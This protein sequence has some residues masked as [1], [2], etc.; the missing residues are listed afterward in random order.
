M[1]VTRKSYNRTRPPVP[2][3]NLSPKENNKK[4]QS[5]SKEPNHYKAP[6]NVEA[7]PSNA[8][9]GEQNKAITQS[10][11][12]T[13]KPTVSKTKPKPT[14]AQKRKGAHTPSNQKSH[15]FQ[16]NPLLKQFKPTYK[17]TSNIVIDLTPNPS[18][19]TIT[20]EAPPSS[21]SS[22]AIC[23]NKPSPGNVPPDISLLPT[24]TY[25]EFAR[26][27]TNK[28]QLP[29]D[30]NVARNTNRSASPSRGCMVDGRDQF[31]TKDQGAIPRMLGSTQGFSD[32][33]QEAVANSG[34]HE[35]LP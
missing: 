10:P 22:E 20:S 25:H 32:A 14:A 3:P 23:S 19:D 16:F 34:G 1:I 29:Q 30:Q 31:E 11:K 9:P 15:K 35:E 21:S 24:Q 28:N 12:P 8:G 27:S 6:V 7:G 18:P 17:P 33:G 26:S 2:T 4:A 13:S 5:I